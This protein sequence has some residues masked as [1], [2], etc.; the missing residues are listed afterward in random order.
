MVQLFY[1]PEEGV[2]ADFIPFWHDGAFRLFYLKDFRD[3][4]RHGE[5]TPWYQVVTRDFLHFTDCGE[6]LARG[7]ADEQ[8]LY[9]FTGS[10]YRCGGQ[11]HIFYT[12]H[13]GHFVPRGLPC[14]GVM[15]AVSEDLVHWRKLPKHSFYADPAQYEIHDFRDPFVFWNEAERKH[16]MLLVMRKKDSGYTAGFTARFSSDDLV[17]WKQEPDLWAPGLYHTHECPDLFCIGDWWYLIFSEYS[18]RSMTRYVMARSL[19]G[20]WIIPPDDCFDG[21]AYYAAKSCP[22]GE[23]RYLFGWIPTKSGNDDNGHW[24]WGGNLAVHEL[25]QRADGTLGCRMP[26]TMREAWQE[27]ARTERARLSATGA[28][29]ERLL[30]GGV[31]ARYRVDASVTFGEGTRQFGIAIGQ[32]YAQKPGYKY[33]FFPR[34]GIVKFN[35]V[36]SPIN[37]KDVT[38]PLALTPGMPVRLSVVVEDDICVL[39]ANDEIAL[40][41]RM[42]NIAGQD[43]S[44]FVVNGDIEGEAQLLAVRQA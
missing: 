3:A 25:F 7:T 10:V 39:Y 1:R 29:A 8:D 43:V 6:M 2:A 11:F 19:D 37:T 31:G 4:L 22:D 40:S 20:P 30:F 32:N 17:T 21:R 44:L 28:K 24:Q 27:T 35:A 42:Y 13:N 38:R 12:G 33:E 14:Q 16:N 26:R 36:T 23:A 9:V 5:G 15:H 34:E 18:D 41:A